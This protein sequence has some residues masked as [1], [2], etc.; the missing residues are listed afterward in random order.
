MYGYR[1]RVKKERVMVVK[2]LVRCAKHCDGTRKEREFC[3]MLRGLV[4]VVMSAI[5]ASRRARK[6]ERPFVMIRRNS[7]G[8]EGPRAAGPQSSLLLL[9]RAD[10]TPILLQIRRSA[11]PHRHSQSNAVR[12]RFRVPPT[13]TT[14]GGRERSVLPRKATATTGDPTAPAAAGSLASNQPEGRRAVGSDAVP[15]SWSRREA[16]HAPPPVHSSRGMGSGGHSTPNC[17]CRRRRHRLDRRRVASSRTTCEC[18]AS[19]RRRLSTNRQ[20]GSASVARRPA[21][22]VDVESRRHT[23]A[24]H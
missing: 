6:A 14:K 3:E 24:R 9:I 1:E 21:A 11:I 12:A 20:L 5:R 4:V 18:R 19:F 22:A 8:P 2:M 13:T 7:S 16:S 23:S 15:S 10:A 17:R